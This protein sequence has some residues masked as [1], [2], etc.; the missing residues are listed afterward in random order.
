[1]IGCFFFKL[2]ILCALGTVLEMATDKLLDHIEN[3]EWHLLPP[4]VQQF[5]KLMI[6][7]AQGPPHLMTGTKPLN[8]DTFVNVIHTLIKKISWV[9]I[10][11]LLYYSR[12]WK[13][14]TRLQCLWTRWNF[15]IR[16]SFMLRKFFGI[17]DHPRIVLQLYDYNICIFAIWDRLSIFKKYCT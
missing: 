11:M 15:K 1:M 7:R 17:I 5:V 2:F 14:F 4:N 8:F 6:L 13:L 16:S 12:L 9:I 10:E 3:S